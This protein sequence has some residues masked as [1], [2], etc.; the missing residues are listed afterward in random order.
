MK[1]L[2][3]PWG[4]GWDL[5]GTHDFQPNFTFLTPHT[6]WYVQ[7]AALVIGHVAGSRSRT[8]GRSASS[9]RRGW[10]SGRSTRCSC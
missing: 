4:R 9:T 1:L 5:F 6:I 10:R 8:T 7:V 2:S 3:D